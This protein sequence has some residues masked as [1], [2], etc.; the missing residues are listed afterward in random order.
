MNATG[1]HFSISVSIA[2]K[3]SLSNSAMSLS[4]PGFGVVRSFGP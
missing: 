3:P 2:R 1:S 4:R